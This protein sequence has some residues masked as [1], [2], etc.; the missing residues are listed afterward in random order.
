MSILLVVGLVIL[1]LAIFIYGLRY[2]TLIEEPFKGILMFLACCAAALFIL[3][4][5]GVA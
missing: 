1:A 3:L 5:A 4:K 2:V